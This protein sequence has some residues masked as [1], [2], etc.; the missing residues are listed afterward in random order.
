MLVK[1]LPTKSRLWVGGDKAAPEAA[2]ADCPRRGS[3]QEEVS[4]PVPARA[5]PTAGSGEQSAGST[6]A[7]P[8]RDR[9][10]V[11]SFALPHL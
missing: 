7:S 1:L 6:H 9:H 10:Q 4:L 8:S 11:R 2:A 3:W 5:A